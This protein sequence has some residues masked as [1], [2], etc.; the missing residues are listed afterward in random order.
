MDWQTVITAVVASLFS[1]SLITAGIIYLVKKGIDRAID[2]RYERLLEETKLQAQ[3]NVRR[4][5][6]LYDQQSTVLQEL[7][8]QVHRLRRLARDLSTLYMSQERPKKKS[9]ELKTVYLEFEDRFRDFREFIS[10]NRTLLTSEY[11]AAQHEITSLVSSVKSYHQL[12]DHQVND[13]L[14]DQAIRRIQESLNRLDDE[15]LRLLNLAQVRLGILE[16]RR[17]DGIA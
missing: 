13:D 12:L 14:A 8:A 2:L 3:E 10:S 4:K 1:S 6:A 9:N 11:I 15:Y 16:D 17:R 5:A 7:V